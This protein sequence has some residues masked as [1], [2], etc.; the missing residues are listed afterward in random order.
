MKE[1][2]KNK[3]KQ[4]EEVTLVDRLVGE[5]E[6]ENEKNTQ[7]FNI[8]NNIDGIE[9]EEE[10]EEQVQAKN[11]NGEDYF[12]VEKFKRTRKLTDQEKKAIKQK[13]QEN[14]RLNKPITTKF[15]LMFTIPTILSMIIMNAFGLVDGIFAMRGIDYTAF[16]AVNIVFPFLAF[17]MAFG[18]MLT[19]GGCALV[20]KLKGQNKRLEARQVFTFLTIV[21]FILSA[22]ISL[23]AWFIREPLV[24]LMGARGEGVYLAL[25]YF[26]P[27]ILM[28]PFIMLGVFF[29]QYI[30]AD[31]KP[32][33]GM[34]LTILASVTSTGLNAIF[35]FVLDMGIMG[36]ALATGI[37]Y[38][39]PALLGLVYFIFNRKGTL[40]FV[41]PKFDLRALGRSCL[42]GI[43]ESITMMAGVFTTI[44]LNN[45]LQSIAGVEPNPVYG[46][47]YIPGLGVNPYYNIPY[48]SMGDAYVAIVGVVIQTVNL[49]GALFFGYVSGVAPIVSYNFGK[50]NKYGKE[51]EKGAERHANIQK[52]FKRSIIIVF[53]LSV[54]AVALTNIFGNLLLRVYDIYPANPESGFMHEMAIFGIRIASIALIMMG[55]NVFATGWFTAFNDGL[56]SGAMSILRSLVFT[57]TLL[58]TLPRAMGLSGAWTALPLV[59]FLGLVVTVFFLWKMSKKYHYLKERKKIMQ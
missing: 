15:L 16:A 6:E 50:K 23:I 9:V 25:E 3:T 10:V 29:T 46:I 54:V 28:T 53:I 26:Q 12:K 2:E 48:F 1:E 36:L 30:I 52:L 13:Y 5:L 35:L 31:G 59:E 22:T 57:I 24:R 39:I 55:I 34:L 51:S 40:F 20:A 17:V 19:M 42:N 8:E 43:S 41:R 33:L 18:L 58:A 37:G 7:N 47:P 44:V 45:T 21:V 56:V 27:L 38:S 49:L 32:G 11:E 4:Q 14:S